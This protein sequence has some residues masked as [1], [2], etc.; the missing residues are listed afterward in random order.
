M[1]ECFKPFGM[2]ELL[3]RLRAAIRRSTVATLGGDGAVIETD[4]FTID[5]TAK[6]LLRNGANV[7]LTPPPTEWGLLEILARNRGK[8][9]TQPRPPTK[10]GVPTSP[11][12]GRD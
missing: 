11:K 12:P 10:H 1:T 8:L 4:T 6:K 3:A 9:I 5:L 7:H 2:D